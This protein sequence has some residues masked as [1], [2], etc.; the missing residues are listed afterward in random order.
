MVIYIGTNG[1]DIYGTGSIG[2]PFRTLS[3]AY[4]NTEAPNGATFIFLKPSS[5]D[6]LFTE[7]LNLEDA[8][9][10][11]ISGE[12]PTVRVKFDQLQIY[13]STNIKLSSLTFE[14]GD[15]TA[16]KS[17]YEL[18]NVRIQNGTERFLLSN[19]S[20]AKLRDVT[21]DGFYM[22]GIPGSPVLDFDEE[23]FSSKVMVFTN[24]GE[25]SI[26]GLK[27][28]NGGASGIILVDDDVERIS[29]K[30]INSTMVAAIPL[31]ITSNPEVDS[32]FE[33]DDVQVSNAGVSG[34]FLAGMRNTSIPHVINRFK[35]TNCANGLEFM[36]SLVRIHNVTVDNCGSGI[37]ARNS[38][39]IDLS[40]FLATRCSMGLRPTTGSIIN[41]DYSNFFDNTNNFRTTYTKHSQSVTLVEHFTRELEFNNLRPDSETVRHAE[42]ELLVYP[43]ADYV[44][45]YGS[46]FTAATLRRSIDS[47]IPSGAPLIVH[48]EYL[49][50]FDE[51]G[52]LNQGPYVRFV[53]P[54]YKDESLEYSEFSPMIDSGKVTGFYFKGRAPNIGYHETERTLTPEE[55]LFEIDLKKQRLPLHVPRIEN[56]AELIVD[57]MR[58]YDP[59]LNVSEGTALKD[60]VVKPN[61]LIIDLPLQ[62]IEKISRKQSILFHNEM[63][64]F[65]MDELIANYF[66]TRKGGNRS[67]GS[68]RVTVN[69][70]V[71]TLINNGFSFFY[72]G[73]SYIVRV[74]QFY[75]RDEILFNFMA[76]GLYYY[77]VNVEAEL[78]GDDH[79][80]PAGGILTTRGQINGLVSIT[81][82]EGIFG[83]RYEENN[84]DL[85][86]RSRRAWSTRALTS[87]RSIYTV[88]REEFDEV[89]DV[90]SIGKDDPEMQRDVVPELRR[91]IGDFHFGGMTDVYVWPYRIESYV[92]DIEVNPQ[93]EIVI[94]ASTFFKSPLLYITKVELLDE[95]DEPH[96]D[97][98]SNEYYF[99][100]NHPELRFSIREQIRMRFYTPEKYAF[101]KIRIH[102]VSSSLI[103]RVQDFFAKEDVRNLCTDSLVKIFSPVI[104]DGTI[105]VE[106]YLEEDLAE[107]TKRV[108]DFF[109]NFQTSEKMSLKISSLDKFLC[110]NGVVEYENPLVFN[111]T[112]WQSDGSINRY[113]IESEFIL[114]RTEHFIPGNI[115]VKNRI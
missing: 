67:K 94:D 93:G 61:S 20:K 89:I 46:D 8:H 81:A 100:A 84:E 47:A 48:Y 115:E 11:T 21:I 43:K 58:A 69:R 77:D 27:T 19:Q 57:N 68:V 51:G 42:S 6:D 2:N 38:S 1:S 33:A 56:T 3:H 114:R 96:S 85:Y 37:L 63:E 49:D 55:I 99:S 90:V 25:V 103:S 108:R 101:S 74:N 40:N 45:T 65:E 98:S 91:Y 64:N 62:E 36:E 109:H 29:L 83:G 73:K 15:L 86:N 26:D 9:G 23:N 34:M 76:G 92:Q 97:I 17:T 79:E 112:V 13:E 87:P 14:E 18:F 54:Q 5:E 10:I 30:R 82:P 75:S 106:N 105:W 70:A 28:E 24:H 12:N 22:S 60:I 52:Q 39:I 110:E 59:E 53:D 113:N 31:W 32:F 107:A 104:I 95:Y 44:I 4:N 35:S 88:A 72:S 71:D 16:S 50:P 78:E 80:V 66:I 41:F 7:T 111:V 102:Y